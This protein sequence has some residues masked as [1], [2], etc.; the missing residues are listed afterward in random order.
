MAH[1]WKQLVAFMLV[2]IVVI[3]Q[4]WLIHTH[5]S[6]T[7]V[8][9]KE[10]HG[11]KEE[12][13]DLRK[14]AVQAKAAEDFL[15]KRRLLTAKEHGLAQREAAILSKEKGL[16]SAAAEA[17]AGR[18]SQVDPTSEPASTPGRVKSTGWNDWHD[19]RKPRLYCMVPF[20]WIKRKYARH[21]AIMDSWGQRCD[22]I[23]FFVD[24]PVPGEEDG[25]KDIPAN[26]VI[27]NM[28]RHSVDGDQNQK[29]IWEKMWRSWIW[30][31]DHKLTE[32]DWFLKVDDDNYFFPDNVKAFV[33]ERGW[34]PWDAKYFGH[35]VYHRSIP[36]IAGAL[37]GFSRST[38]G[39]ISQVYKTMPKGGKTDERGRCEDR[40]GATEELSTAICLKT[41]GIVAED[42]QDS[43]GE[44]GV[45]LFQPQAH[46]YD[47][48]RPPLGHHTEG[49]FWAKKPVGAGDLETCCSRR[50]LAFHG[51]KGAGDF[52]MLEEFFYQE[53]SLDKMDRWL[54]A[55]RNVALKA[56]WAE[57]RDRIKALP[58]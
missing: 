48:K 37:E 50:P 57:V 8:V 5:H 7:A 54:N 1:S 19:N 24:S 47:M 39:Q 18:G 16:A 13:V 2:A 22:G 25:F 31:A 44:E 28:T 51:F 49:W 30:V 38:L 46:W 34:S 45:M 20:M 9:D 42:T 53:G 23:N 3:T 32:Y 6:M 41:L 56:Y 43:L 17:P 21:K 12:N 36:I 11:H 40:K 29:H 26:M 27:I 4:S 10:D 33:Q 35:K 14:L 55:K 58:K 52:K 15:E